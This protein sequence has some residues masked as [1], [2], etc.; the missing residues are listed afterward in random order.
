MK[1]RILV[2]LAFTIML[3][4]GPASA[5]QG[6]GAI[7]QP[8]G[9]IIGQPGAGFG[10]TIGQPGTGF[11]GTFGQPGTGTGFGGTFGQP[12]TGT[13]G[14]LGTGQIV[15]DQF[16]NPFFSTPNVFQPGVTFIPSQGG[17][18]FPGGYGGGYGPWGPW[19]NVTTMGPTSLSTGGVAAPRMG[20]TPFNQPLPFVARPA[21]GTRTARVRVVPQ[22]SPTGGTDMATGPTSPEEI[23]V[24]QRATAVMADRPLVPATVTAVGA[25]GIQVRYESNGQI[26]TRRLPVTEVFFFSNGD[27]AAADTAPGMLRVGDR[28]MVPAADVR[29]AVA[30]ARQIQRT[31]NRG[32]RRTSPAPRVRIVPRRPASRSTL[33]PPTFMS[34]AGRRF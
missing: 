21:T 14:P 12:G 17:G 6:G 16:G 33:P 26:L 24:A 28:V 22:I 23:R 3:A 32:I 34:Y 11:G 19:G 27:L 8:G 10:G 1:H 2:P 5:Q 29:E 9:G 13:F 15:F 7:G 30:G 25:T 20:L 4:S 31:N 18:F